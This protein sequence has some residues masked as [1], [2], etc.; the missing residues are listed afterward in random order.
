[1]E[2]TGPTC[3][4][5][6]DRLV[7]EKRREFAIQRSVDSCRERRIRQVLEQA[8]SR[9][10]GHLL[11]HLNEHHSAINRSRTTCPSFF[12]Y[13]THSQSHP[14]I[15]PSLS[16]STFLILPHY[17]HRSSDI[18]TPSLPPS[19]PSDSIT[20]LIYSL[21]FSHSIPIPPSLNPSLISHIHSLPPSLQTSSYILHTPSL[22][23]SLF[24][25][26]PISQYLPKPIAHL[27]YSLIYLICMTLNFNRLSPSEDETHFLSSANDGTFKLWSYSNIEG[28]SATC[29]SKFT[30]NKLG[31]QVIS[32]MLCLQISSEPNKYYFIY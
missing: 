12:L 24:L 27:T 13:I 5:S 25:S 2:F 20:H 18:F 28:Q 32:I 16:L 8:N 23:P 17:T 26:L 6:L 10:Q 14:Y 29:R 15:T 4:S 11:I 3:H 21:P 7:R 22:H 19:L 31:G 9:P 1:M 30:Y